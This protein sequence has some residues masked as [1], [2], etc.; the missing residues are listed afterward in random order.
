M[1]VREPHQPMTEEEAYEKAIGEYETE[2]QLQQDLAAPQYIEKESQYKFM[3]D[4]L[5]VQNSVKVANLTTD[6][7]GNL[8]LSVRGCLQI[9]SMANIFGLDEYSKY[10]SNKAEIIAATSMSRYVKG[11]NFL[12]LIFTQIRKHISGASEAKTEQKNKLF[13]W[14]KKQ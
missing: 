8:K 6:E 10:Y 1:E 2:L 12:N 4:I 5:N 11:S 14:G 13:S 7:L 3:R 9:S